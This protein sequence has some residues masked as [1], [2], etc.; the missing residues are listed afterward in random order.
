[1]ARKDI[2]LKEYFSGLF[3]EET[4]RIIGE[5]QPAEKLR[6]KDGF[7]VKEVGRTVFCVDSTYL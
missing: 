6:E 7:V 4:Q 2:F 3:F 5:E 1:M